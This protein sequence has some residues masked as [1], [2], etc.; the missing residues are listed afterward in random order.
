M[1]GLAENL[2][3]YPLAAARAVEGKGVFRGSVTVCALFA[4]TQCLHF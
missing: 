3:E 2:L 4:Q 1:L